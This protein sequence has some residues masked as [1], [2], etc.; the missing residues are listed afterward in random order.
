MTLKERTAFISLVASF[1]LAVVKLVIGLMIAFNLAVST[2]F[3]RGEAEGDGGAA[4]SWLPC[5][6]VMFI[7]QVI[8]WAIGDRRRCP[9]CG[10]DRD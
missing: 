5:V 1:S 4:C 3:W 6:A 2:D 7:L 9:K 10:A 8:A